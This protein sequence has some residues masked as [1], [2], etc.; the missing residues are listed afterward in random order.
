VQKEC[1]ILMDLKVELG[2]FVDKLTI[3]DNEVKA[4]FLRINRVRMNVVTEC[5]SLLFTVN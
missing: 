1:E 5:H 3:K 2:K 4:S